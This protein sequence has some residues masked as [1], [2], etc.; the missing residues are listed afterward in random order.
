MGPGLILNTWDS[1]RW[2]RLCMLLQYQSTLV[3]GPLARYVKLWVAHA[4]GMPGTF[5]PPPWISDPNMHHGTCAIHVPWYM[6]GLLTSG[7]LWSQWWGNV[8]GI[9]GACATRNFTNLVR[10]PWLRR[11]A[12]MHNELE[13]ET[14]LLLNP[15]CEMQNL[16]RS[17]D[18]ISTNIHTCSVYRY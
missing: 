3:I 15:L 6:P 7:S 11:M 10:G 8:T 16:A 13:L 18:D 14:V 2:S 9:P 1:C 12:T 5:S 17:R 4:P